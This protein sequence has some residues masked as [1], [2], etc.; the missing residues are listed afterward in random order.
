MKTALKTLH[1]WRKRKTVYPVAQLDDDVKHI[2]RQHNQKADHLAN[3]ETEGKKS[4]TIEGVIFFF[5]K[6]KK[7]ETQSTG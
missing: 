5:E 1:S 4:I 2:F 7:K 6:K 3:A